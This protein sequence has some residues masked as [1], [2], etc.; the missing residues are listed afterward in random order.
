MS[1]P[2]TDEALAA[3][4]KL[5]RVLLTSTA[6]R[7][8]HLDI[9]MQQLRAMFLL[10]DEE[11]ASVGRLAKLFGIGLPAASLLADRLVQ[12]GYIERREDPT[13]RRRVLL[14]LTRV[15]VRLVTDLREGS[16]SLL[17]RWMSSLSPQ[18]LAA[19][20]RGWRALADVASGHG[21]VLEHGGV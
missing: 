17:R 18:D 4:R 13:D 3:Y 14:S 11:E 12:A 1:Q 2:S 19:L 8:L 21:A 6:S 20:T 15:G 16:Q 10:R 5:H 9:S 7:W